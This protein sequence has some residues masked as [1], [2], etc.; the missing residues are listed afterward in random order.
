MFNL[1]VFGGINLVNPIAGNIIQYYGWRTCCYAMG[2]AFTLQVILAFFFM[3]ETAFHRP[4]ALNLD[5]TSHEN[6]AEASQELKLEKNEHVENLQKDYPELE[7]ARSQAVYTRS[8]R[9]FPSLKE[10]SPWSGYNHKVNLIKITL[11]PFR[12]VTSVATVY[13]TILFAT[14]ISWLVMIAVTSSLIFAS[15]PY[16][17][18]I[19][20]VGL[21][22]LSGFVAQILGTLI[23]QPLSDGVAVYLAKKNGGVYGKADL[24]IVQL[25]FTN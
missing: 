25:P 2:G 12:L 1:G 17:F 7:R 22:S 15:P 21:T 10:L 20:Q 5:T 16:N 9:I 6:L 11:R 13:G 4:D 8:S 19:A 18:T 23:A 24:P 14:A 3:P